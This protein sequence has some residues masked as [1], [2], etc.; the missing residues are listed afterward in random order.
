[1]GVAV[2]EDRYFDIE[3]L[4]D[5]SGLSPNTLRRYM[6]DPVNPLPNHHVH[7][8][9]RDRGRTLIAKREFDAWVARFPPA[10]GKARP[11]KADTDPRFEARVAAA[12]RSIR[13]K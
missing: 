1:M 10:R 5:Y 7:G 11:A 13:G 12:V 4:A 6:A 2:E 8:T 9:G 3:A